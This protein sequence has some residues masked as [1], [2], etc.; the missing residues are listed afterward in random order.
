MMRVYLHHANDFASS[1]GR[2]AIYAFAVGDELRMM[3][4][5]LKRFTKIDPFNL[6]EARRR[7]ADKLLNENCYPF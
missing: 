2:Q 1:S 7:V 3:L 6:K 4:M 5:G